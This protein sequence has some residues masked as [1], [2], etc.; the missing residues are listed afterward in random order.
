MFKCPF[1]PLQG[2]RFVVSE[3]ARLAELALVGQGVVLPIEPVQVGPADM[4]V[5]VGYANGDPKIF[6]MPDAFQYLFRQYRRHFL[7]H[8]SCP[9]YSLFC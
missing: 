5:P 7:T 1:R 8:G 4:D 2:H 9:L 3:L 6:I